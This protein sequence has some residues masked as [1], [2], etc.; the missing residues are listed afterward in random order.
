MLN[1]NLVALNTHDPYAHIFNQ[2]LEL[3]K[4][5]GAQLELLSTLS[6]VYD[7]RTPVGY[8]PGPMGYTMTMSDTFWNA[9]QTERLEEKASVLKV[10]LE[11]RTQAEKQ[12]VRAEII[13]V[14][15]DPG[16]VI[17]DRAKAEQADLII[18]G[19]HGRRGLDELLVC[20]VSSYVMHRATCSVMV[21]HS[22]TQSATTLSKTEKR[23]SLA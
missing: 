12:G 2:S 19:S 21:V 1:T 8:Y 18:V 9:Y 5:T 6:T 14:S 13:Q 4:A 7:Y 11:L 10:L 3:A 15:G 22:A 17:C 23:V 16:V 20:C